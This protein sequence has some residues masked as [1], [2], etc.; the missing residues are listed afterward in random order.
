MTHDTLFHQAL[1]FLWRPENDG[2][3]YYVTPGLAGGGVA[4]GVSWS[5]FMAWRRLHGTNGVGGLLSEFMTM[6]RDDFRPFYQGAI[7][8][9]LRASELPPGFGLMMFDAAAMHGVAR[10]TRWLQR[11]LETTQ[12]AVIDDGTLDA[13][14]KHRP[15]TITDGYTNLRL[16]F[17]NDLAPEAV[18][19]DGFLNGWIRRA[20]AG[21]IEAN[22]L[23]VANPTAALRCRARDAAVAA[24]A[25]RAAALAE[26]A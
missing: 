21:Q 23:A 20:R 18:G 2:Q 8:N 9:A 7:W 16:A 19:D 11:A 22:S 17:Y 3:P 26:T 13:L 15:Q 1:D 6:K 5:T 25:T 24:L 4:W 12:T 10:A 14:Y